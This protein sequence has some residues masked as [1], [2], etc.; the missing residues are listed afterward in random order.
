M[1]HT[2]DP[3]F[4]A[5]RIVLILSLLLPCVIQA[6]THIT[7][8]GGVYAKKSNSLLPFASV[9]LKNKFK[10]TVA[11][12]EGFFAFNASNRTPKRHAGN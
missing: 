7:I 3:A 2:N 4:C 11:N 12:N 8:T 10:G 9:N 6:Q 1:K 5:P